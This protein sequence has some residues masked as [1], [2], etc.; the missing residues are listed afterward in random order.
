MKRRKIFIFF[1]SLCS[2][3]LICISAYFSV[4]AQERAVTRLQRKNPTEMTPE[5]IARGG[6]IFV[7]KCAG[8]HGKRADGRGAQAV[9]LIP[10]PKNLR[11]GGFIRN[12]SD[13]RIYT[14]ISGGVRGTAMPA[15]EM[16]LHGDQR[17]DVINYVRSLTQDD[18]LDIPSAIYDEE[19]LPEI[20]N[21]IPLDDASIQ[22]GKKFYTSY[23][24]RC[25]GSEGDGQGKVSKNLKPRP[26][27]LVVIASW[28]EIPF[29]NYLDDMR[30]YNSITHG[31]PGTSMPP[32]GAVLTASERWHLINYLRTEAKKKKTNYSLSFSEE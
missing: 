25:H 19:V 3:T 21:P 28:G 14:S 16:I 5:S 1:V 32:W 17:W 26:R 20:Q 6:T 11:N 13:E 2:V 29:L 10:K 27:N 24:M 30:V 4:F 12:L 8:C 9:N 31:I 18:D 22:T 15:F 23:C 7:E